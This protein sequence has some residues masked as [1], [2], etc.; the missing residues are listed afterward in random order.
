MRTRPYTDRERLASKRDVKKLF[1]IVTEGTKTEQTYFQDLSADK[2]FKHPSVHIETIQAEHSSP[3]HVLAS[4]TEFNNEYELSDNDELWLVIDRDRW[5]VLTLNRVSQEAI[6]K[7]FLLADSN[8]AFE[9]WLLFHHRSLADYTHQEIAKLQANP[10]SG[11]RTRLELELISICGSF[12]KSN[13]KTSD[14]MPTI[15]AAI[16]NAK[17]SDVRPDDRWLNQIGSRVYKLVESI[18]SSTTSP[19][20]PGN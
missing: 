1:V 5:E 9:L 18:I 10:R 6:Q 20:N 17:N 3:E 8:P 12:S 7:G 13:L 16:A 4:L 14:Y 11:S 19:N 2:R 15:E